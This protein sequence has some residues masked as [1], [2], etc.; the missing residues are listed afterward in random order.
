MKSKAFGGSSKNGE[1]MNGFKS[2]RKINGNIPLKKK[3]KISVKF[4]MDTSINKKAFR[5]HLKAL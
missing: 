5:N 2:T 4:T 1:I 3:G